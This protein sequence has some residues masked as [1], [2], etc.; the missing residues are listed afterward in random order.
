MRRN[1]RD[2]QSPL[3]SEFETRTAACDGHRLAHHPE[4]AGSNSVP[5][6]M[7]PRY[8]LQPYSSSWLR[9]ACGSSPMSRRSFMGFRLGMAIGRP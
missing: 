7:R 6:T 9:R 1:Y 3:T 5:A 8:P 4:V 2:R